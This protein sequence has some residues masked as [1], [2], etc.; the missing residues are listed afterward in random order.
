MIKWAFFT[1]CGGNLSQELGRISFQDLGSRKNK[2]FLVE[3]APM[4]TTNPT[5]IYLS[6]SLYELP[7]GLGPGVRIFQCQQLFLILLFKY[8]LV[9]GL[10]L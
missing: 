6:I 10:S 1:T 4:Q 8:T 3:Y 5:Q 2:D 7:E 9:R